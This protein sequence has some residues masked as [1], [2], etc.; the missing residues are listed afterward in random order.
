MG[1]PLTLVSNH[2]NLEIRNHSRYTYLC[3]GGLSPTCSE[4][5][6][7]G[8]Q[9]VAQVEWRVARVVPSVKID[10]GK[11]CVHCA[12]TKFVD[13]KIAGGHDAAA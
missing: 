4:F 8:D 13:I 7:K 3:D 6:R 1:M 11:F 12:L 5:I 10:T 9:Y 2:R